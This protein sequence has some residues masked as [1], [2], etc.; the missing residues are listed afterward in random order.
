MNT[1]NDE[2][3]QPL[4]PDEIKAIGEIELGP[5]KH[6][7]F[8]NKHYKKLL[9]G[10]IALGIAS[11]CIIAF[12]SHR[13]DVKQEAAAEVVAAMKLTTPA[14]VAQP[15]QY[16]VAAI[17]A[18]LGD[19]AST[20]SGDT[21]KLMAGMRLL[22]GENAERGTAMLEALAAKTDDTL[23]KAR[24]LSAVA[25]HHL[26]EGKEDKA[27]EAWKKVT[28]AGESP[29]LAL[30]Y[31]TLGDLARAK[32]D[33]EAARAAYTDAQTKCA[34]SPLV[35]NKTAEMRLLLLDVDAPKPV[36]APKKEDGET[37]SALDEA[38]KKDNPFG[39]EEEEPATTEP[40]PSLDDLLK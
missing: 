18:L 16:D 12:F 6:E 30:A 26:A 15:A 21:G 36:A 33:I 22:E 11:G 13:N 3:I 14:Q 28:E 7:I 8:L 19:Y 25:A 9:W 39:D 34:T 38:P 40:T 32:G 1:K 4:T 24:A 35:T 23:I 27:A 20:P 17:D 29:Y 5:A 10:G 37:P 2:D 31:I